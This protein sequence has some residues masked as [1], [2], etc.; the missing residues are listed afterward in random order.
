MSLLLLLNGN[1]GAAPAPTYATWDPNNKGSGIVL[2][3]GN[4]DAVAGDLGWRM[5][6]GTVPVGMN[7]VTKGQF[8][9]TANAATI[10]VGMHNSNPPDLNTFLGGDGGGNG[11]GYY[12]LVGERVFGGNAI[13]FGAPTWGNGD[14]ITVLWDSG[15]IYF[16]KNNGTPI[17][18]RTFGSVGGNY[19]P[20]VAVYNS[21]TP[22]TA[23]A[24]FG[25][26]A[27]AYPEPGYP[28]VWGQPS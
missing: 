9:I 14:I 11:I 17:S 20:A 13:G 4:L 5:V 19:Y 16:K 1:N 27:L 10:I 26:T 22:D 6:L 18:P 24:C 7:G 28:L 21:N 2:Q 8:Q 23:A 25:F 3:N 12:G 15:T